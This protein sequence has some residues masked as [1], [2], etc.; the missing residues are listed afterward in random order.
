MDNRKCIYF[1]ESE[2][3][4]KLLNALLW[5]RKPPKSFSFVSQDG[6]KIKK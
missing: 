3:E 6:D 2:C 1:V 5:T 4:E